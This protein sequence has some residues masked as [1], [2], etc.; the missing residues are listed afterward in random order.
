MA[1][2]IDPSTTPRAPSARRGRKSGVAR[3]AADVLAPIPAPAASNDLAAVADAE[4]HPASA[5]PRPRQPRSTRPPSASGDGSASHAA[6]PR[7]RARKQ[8]GSTLPRSPLDERSLMAHL[9]R[10]LLDHPL[11]DG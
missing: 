5:A 1:A 6:A 7:R 10:A 8:T 2:A 11:D 4:T 9:R 3:P